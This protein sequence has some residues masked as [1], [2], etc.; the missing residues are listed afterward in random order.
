MGHAEG[1][2][3][4]TMDLENYFERGKFALYNQEEIPMMIEYT[5]KDKYGNVVYKNRGN[6]KVWIE[7]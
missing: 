4:T 6:K 5:G 3:D 7:L 1:R 2:L